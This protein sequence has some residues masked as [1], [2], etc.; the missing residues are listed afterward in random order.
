MGD[1]IEL[2]RGSGILG[3]EITGSGK[4]TGEFKA[5]MSDGTEVLFRTRGKKVEYLD[6]ETWTEIG[7]NI[8][9]TDA[10]GKDISF[11]QHNS[12]AGDQLY[13]SS[14]YGPLI[15]IMIANPG[16]YADM[17]VAGTNYKGY[18]K[19]S[20]NRMFLWGRR[21]NR[22]TV[23]LSHIDDVTDQKTD[24]TAENVG[25][26]DGTTKTF[27][28]TLAFKAGGAKRTCFAIEATD[29]TET[30]TDNDRNGTLTGSLGGTGTINYMS[31]AISLTF[32]TA[33]ANLQAIT[34]NY[35]WIDDTSSGVCDFTWTTSTRIAG[36]GTF[37]PQNEGGDI[38]NIFA[39]GDSEY[40]MHKTKTWVINLTSDDTSATNYIYREKVGI[41]SHGAGVATGEGIYFIDTSDAKDYQ[42]K[43]LTLNNLS[44]LVLPESI[45]QQRTYK[46]KKVGIDLSSYYFDKCVGTEWGNFIL[47]AFRTSVSA[48]NNRVLIYDK[49]LKSIDILDYLVSAF[50]EYGG[51]LTG[52][53]SY[54][55]NVFTLFSGYDDDESLIIN[56]WD[57]NN[58]NLD[59]DGLKKV[60]KLV[61]QGDIGPEQTIEVWTK[62]DNDSFVK[63]GEIKGNGSYV[64]TAK[65]SLVGIHTLGSKK[66]GAESQDITAY[67]YERELPFNQDKFDL[68]KIRFKAAGLGYA[69]ISSYR[70]YDVRIKSRKRPTKYRS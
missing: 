37:F 60:K 40:C 65:L 6:D 50:A 68:A 69:S 49:N 64:D 30:F 20:Q 32:N 12:L 52:G 8:L 16:S 44:G 9:G 13:I 29:G 22:T 54:G 35:S 24:V 46:G 48:E 7:T 47:F 11:T 36:E 1:K 58:D 42:V 2:K 15:K 56:N 28:D 59:W 23:Y 67:A 31:G 53:D 70:F 38:Q 10:D 21:A 25:T 61:I 66:V 26:G 14:P 4:I 45:S 55:K 62:A 41:P 39:Y 33:P 43:I 27:T 51:T 19:M 5:V 17:Y 18:I 3:N 57:G 63:I 34:C